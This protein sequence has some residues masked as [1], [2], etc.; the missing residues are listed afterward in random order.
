MQLWNSY[1]KLVRKITYVS[2]Y[3]GGFMLVL[4]FLLVFT[5][6]ML[7]T[8]FNS[9]TL[10]SDEISGYLMAGGFFLASAYALQE[11]A[12]VR[13]DILYNK[14]P[15]K[16]RC[17]LDIFIDAIVLCYTGILFRYTFDYMYKSLVKGSRSVSFIKTPLW[18][19]QFFIPL[20]CL[21]LF[22]SLTVL[23]G[24]DFL[25]AAGKIELEEGESATV[26]EIMEQLNIV[27]EDKE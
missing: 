21:I 22:L 24:H 6:V 9:S 19:P 5:E 20:G 7:R 27:K 10:V 18:I 16:I 3:V 2:A 12:I 15:V 13:I 25:K 1:E 23:T 4:M 8:F 11:G 26:K 14:V 17:F